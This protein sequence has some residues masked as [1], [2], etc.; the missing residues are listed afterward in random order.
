MQHLSNFESVLMKMLQI[1]Q[2]PVAIISKE[3]DPNG[4]TFTKMA[5]LINTDLPKTIANSSLMTM[6]PPHIHWEGIFNE[7]LTIWQNITCW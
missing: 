2:N 7:N 1:D 5:F 4:P 6:N 3:N